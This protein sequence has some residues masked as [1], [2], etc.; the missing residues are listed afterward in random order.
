MAD[1]EPFKPKNKDAQALKR[2]ELVKMLSE[3]SKKLYKRIATDRFRAKESD[4]IYLAYART[5]SQI[6]QTL[7]SCLKDEEL[8]ELERRIDELENRQKSEKVKEWN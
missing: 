2:E 8:L 4:Q 7:N 6:S 1:N 5:F 3:V